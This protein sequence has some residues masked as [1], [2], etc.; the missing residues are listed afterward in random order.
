MRSVFPIIAALF[1]FPVAAGAETTVDVRER[2]VGTVYNT[3]KSLAEIQSMSN[4]DSER[5]TGLTVSRFAI[6][7]RSQYLLTGDG[8]RWC[9][10]DLRATVRMGFDPVTVYIPRE[11]R[12]GGCAYRAV[13]AHEM[14]HVRTNRT[15]MRR[16]RPSVRRMITDAVRRAGGRFCS[17]TQ[18]ATK[19][20]A[21][22]AI[23]AG[24]QA[25]TALVNRESDIL[26]RRVDTKAEYKRVSR[27]CKRWPGLR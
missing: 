27:S 21:S 15:V 14:K 25:I 6:D 10:K 17:A 8:R 26:Q 16:V 7:I 4:K 23:E 24:M 2:N 22:V 11:F 1:L 12:R 20:K 3:R 18:E 9:V 13:S 19:K 5:V